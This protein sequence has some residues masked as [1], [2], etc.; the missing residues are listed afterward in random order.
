MRLLTILGFTIAIAVLG[1]KALSA[2]LGSIG[3][4]KAAQQEALAHV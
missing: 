2:G 3:Q 1:S 4:Y